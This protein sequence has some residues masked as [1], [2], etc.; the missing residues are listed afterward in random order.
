[1]PTKVSNTRRAIESLVKL[2][3]AERAADEQVRAEIEPVLA[4]L[5]EIAGRTVRRAEAARLL[6]IS[7]TAL[8]RWIEKGEV[9][10]VLTPEGRK[11]IPLN[12]LLDLLEQVEERRDERGR[13]A[14]AS[15]IRERRRL[16]E[17]IDEEELL[18]RPPRTHR[19]AELQALAYH[20]LVAQRLDEQVVNDARRR[21]RRWRDEAR[22]HPRWADEWE[23][24]LRRPI[25]RIAKA[26]SADTPR[27]RELRQSSPFAG[28][29]TE[30]ELQRVRGVAERRAGL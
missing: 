7:Y 14:L 17:E 4:F 15:A 1:M 19:A 3:R 20:R 11:E 22:I 24:I 2:R 5:E 9:S 26:M 13:F 8:D 16:A 10:A 29:L 21:L 23:R 25:P 27:G 28:V 12:Q 18:P 6:G 30:Q